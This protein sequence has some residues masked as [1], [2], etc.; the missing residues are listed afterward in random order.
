MDFLLTLNN[1]ITGSRII[2]LRDLNVYPAGSYSE[3]Y[4]DKRYIENALS[5]LVDQFNNRL[6]SHKD[7]C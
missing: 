6:I 5:R 3:I 1:I 4:L 7:F 2:E